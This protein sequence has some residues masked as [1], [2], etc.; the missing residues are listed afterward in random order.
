MVVHCRLAFTRGCR[1]HGRS[2]AHFAWRCRA[3]AA[4]DGVYV[5]RVNV[6]ETWEKTFFSHW[7]LRRNWLV[8]MGPIARRRED[9]TGDGV[10]DPEE[11]RFRIRVACRIRPLP[12]LALP[13]ASS[14]A[15]PAPHSHDG[16][17]QNLTEQ[18]EHPD[19]E[20]EAE[21][22]VDE[23]ASSSRV[24]VPL[25]Q[26]LQI[27]QKHFRCDASEARRRLWAG[28]SATVPSDPW[29]EAFVAEVSE[30]ASPA[31][32]REEATPPCGDNTDG[33]G[34]EQ[35][36]S[37]DSASA[38]AAEQH[39]P[40]TITTGILA[41]RSTQKDVLICAPGAGIRRFRYD[42]VFDDKSTQLEVYEAVGA[43]VVAEFLN[44]SSGVVLAYGQTGSGSSLLLPPPM[45]PI[46]H[47]EEGREGEEAAR[48]PT[49]G[50]SPR[51][52]SWVPGKTHS[53]YG[54]DDIASS[55]SGGHHAQHG[56]ERPLS[57]HA[58]I[59]VR[60]A[61]AV[62]ACSGI[63]PR[64]IQEAWHVVQERKANPKVSG[65]LRLTVV[66]VFGNE[67][68]NLLD[69]GAAVGAWH[70]VAARTV[71]ADTTSVGTT[72]CLGGGWRNWPATG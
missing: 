69:G 10:P 8:Q 61:S 58:Q 32:A 41:V 29:S 65:E 66:E 37:A 52:A 45:R 7:P 2:E 47:G 64:A 24:A 1:E 20:Q 11:R 9:D 21:V 44:G 54:P 60:V 40:T 31:P 6:L 53:M 56:Q 18:T 50:S 68:V 67:V 39:L 48:I 63:I 15:Q 14:Q 5:S 12:K 23:D 34:N 3:L 27:I 28:V 62:T 19:Q 55:V 33:N 70:G 38:S 49:L 22:N 30:Q 42:Q 17:L 4:L 35:A 43:P 36:P 16:Q 51:L 71:L 46:P 25:H 72:V 26:R 57:G 13:P 59:P